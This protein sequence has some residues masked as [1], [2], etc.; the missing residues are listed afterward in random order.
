MAAGCGSGGI[1]RGLA[2]ESES[3]ASCTSSDTVRHGTVIVPMNYCLCAS[4][5]SCGLVFVRPSGVRSVHFVVKLQVS[6]LRFLGP[7]VE[8]LG[9]RWNS[10]VLGGTDDTFARSCGRLN[11]TLGAS[12][13]EL[14]RRYETGGTSIGE[15][16][17]RNG[18]TSLTVA[19]VVSIWCWG[20][21][22]VVPTVAALGEGAQ[23]EV[24]VVSGLSAE[25]SAEVPVVSGLSAEVSTVVLF[26]SCTGASS[27]GR[28]LC[29]DSPHLLVCDL[30]T[31]V[32][33]S[34]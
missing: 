27:R 29:Q 18:R 26:V 11:E 5:M 12:V 24:P 8:L 2:G 32:A 3:D 30:G 31:N 25:V 21:S 1:A 13:G 28:C 16:Y 20:A 15:K 7:V 17:P 4:L 22:T 33:R 10:R 6:A 23:T 9:P 19:A 34:P 14:K